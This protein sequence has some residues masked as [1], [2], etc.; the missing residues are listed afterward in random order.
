MPPAVAIDK[1]F[2]HIGGRCVL[3][4]VT[5]SVQ[6]GEVF[7]IL[8]PNG[9]GKSLLLRLLALLEKPSAGSLQLLGRDA[10]AIGGNG[11]A[12]L[13]REVGVVFQGGSLVR[14]LHVFDNILLPL[15][16]SHLNGEDLHRR[17]RLLM[18]RLQLDGLEERYPY[19]LSDGLQR[20]IELKQ[21]ERMTIILTSQQPAHVLALADRVGVL[22]Q[23]RLLFTGTPDELRAAAGADAS[24]RN[25][26]EGHP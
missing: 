14:D 20:R 11:L 10:G 4:G 2:Q 5:L 19:E 26:L 7:A 3:D 15:R 17:G 23:G 16:D 25:V 21:Q 1:V 22:D 9:A 6:E 24:L 13:R 18:M 12:E 8:G